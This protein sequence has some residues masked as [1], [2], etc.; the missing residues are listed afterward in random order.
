[1]VFVVHGALLGIQ[2]GRNIEICNSFEIL[3]E[4]VDGKTVHDA[5][6]FTEKEKQCK[7]AGLMDQ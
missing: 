5:E 1:M 7:L 3:V 4:T 6:F 2:Q